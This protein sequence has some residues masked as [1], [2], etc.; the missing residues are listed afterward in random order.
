MKIRLKRHRHPT[1]EQIAWHPYFPWYHLAYIGGGKYAWLERIHRRAE[2][3]ASGY[4]WHW[5][6]MELR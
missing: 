5:V 4:V 3:S 6:Y 1:P 2:H